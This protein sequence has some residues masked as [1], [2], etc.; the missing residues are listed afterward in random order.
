MPRFSANLAYLFAELPFM[1]RF[2]A[3]AGAGF[4]AV[5]IQFPYS[6]PVKIIKDELERTGLVLDLINMPAGDW[7]GGERGLAVLPGRDEEFCRAVDAA[8][9]YAEAL[10]VYKINC[11]SGIAAP[12]DEEPANMERMTVRLAYAADRLAERGRILLAEGINNFDMPGFWLNG[13]ALARELFAGVAR[14]N[15]LYQFDIYHAARM[16]EDIGRCIR[17]NYDIIGHFQL[18]DAPGRG[19]PG[20]GGIDFPALFRLIDEL[21]YPGRIGLEYVPGPDTAASLSWVGEYGLSL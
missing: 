18:A 13:I 21:G 7:A 5:E 3:A 20:S 8:L 16:G 17:E 10:E 1:E 4:K 2:A 11:L 14:P 15:I 9:E 6:Y 12:C 19:C